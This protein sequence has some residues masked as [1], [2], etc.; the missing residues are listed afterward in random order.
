M[1][2]SGHFLNPAR[3]EPRTRDF[4]VNILRGCGGDFGLFVCIVADRLEKCFVDLV[5]SV[6]TIVTAVPAG[7]WTSLPEAE[8][9]KQQT[10]RKLLVSHYRNSF[11]YLHR[12]TLGKSWQ[13][14]N[15][16]LFSRAWQNVSYDLM[17][18]GLQKGHSLLTRDESFIRFDR[19]WIPE[20]DSKSRKRDVIL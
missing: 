9:Y 20:R 11:R 6:W 10:I 17:Y 13:K 2:S 14:Q 1:V 19:T 7:H 15:Q 16:Q 5:F 12:A 18:P 8:T 4:F 3:P